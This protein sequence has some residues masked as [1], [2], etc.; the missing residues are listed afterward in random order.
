MLGNGRFEAMCF[1]GQKWLCHI[2]GKLRKNV[3][4]TA[5]DIILIGLRDYQDT[6]ADVILKYT[7]DEARNLK[8]YGE[9]P[10]SARINENVEEG[11]MDGDMITVDDYDGSDDDIDDI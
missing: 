5:G 4:I 1:D 7:P 8:T 2:R 10:E 11:D 9:L 6:K 3:W